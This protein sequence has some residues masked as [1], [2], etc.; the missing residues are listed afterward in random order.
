MRQKIEVIAFLAIC[1]MV[2]SFAISAGKHHDQCRECNM[3]AKI[4]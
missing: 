1:V 2:I 4:K 3:A